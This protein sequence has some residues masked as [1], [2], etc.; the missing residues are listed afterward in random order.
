MLRTLICIFLL[1]VFAHANAQQFWQIDK[2]SAGIDA[3]MP[4]ELA[5]KLT[6][7]YK[8]DLEKFRAIFTWITSHIDYKLPS[9]SWSKTQTRSRQNTDTTWESR[10]LDERVAYNVMKNRAAV[11]EGYAR[12]LKTL[13]DYAGISCNVISGYARS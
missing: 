2:R 12:L 10:S 6:A 5:K 9:R 8:T 11:C 3:V 7:P 13:C 4:D 1:A